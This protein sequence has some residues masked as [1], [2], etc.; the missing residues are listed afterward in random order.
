M[1][2]PPTPFFYQPGPCRY[3]RCLEPAC[4]DMRNGPANSPT[5]AGPLPSRA[6]IDRRVGS[7]RAASVELK[8]FTTLWL[9]MPAMEVKRF[10]GVKSRG[11]FTDH[12]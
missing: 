9:C 2:T 11:T 4:C 12:S 1:T 8:V 6:R 10:W 5:V 3:A 7:E